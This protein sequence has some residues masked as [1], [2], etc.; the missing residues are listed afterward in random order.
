MLPVIAAAVARGAAALAAAAGE[1]AATVGRGAIAAANMAGRGLDPLAASLGMGGPVPAVSAAAGVAPPIHHVLGGLAPGGAA[2][3]AAA[4]PV[5]LALIQPPANLPPGG[6]YAPPTTPQQQAGGGLTQLFQTAQTN[7][8]QLVSSGP[9]IT[10]LLRQIRTGDR[11][12]DTAKDL[13]L[14]LVELPGRIRDFGSAVLEARRGLAEYNGQ[15]ANAFTKLEFERFGRNIRLGGMTSKSTE[16]LAG[17][18]SNLEEKLLVYQA[19]GMNTLNRIAEFAEGGA[20]GAIGVLEHMNFLVPVVVK[21]LAGEDK[22]VP[23][24]L[25]DLA[26]RIASGEMFA[27][28][29]RRP[30]GGGSVPGGTV[31][32]RGVALPVAHPASGGP[33]VG[34]GA[35]TGARNGWL[36]LPEEK[37]HK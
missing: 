21:W 36:C 20:G 27:H 31:H 6:Q 28:A 17:A 13:L 14:S 23:T 5:P 10:G 9:T 2:R 16:G 29:R 22:A 26:I 33:S 25:N 18:Q 15:I 4:A 8:Q 35:D 37:I 19:A 11:T 30:P 3:A 12:V 7:V 24:V 32:R 34:G 1:A